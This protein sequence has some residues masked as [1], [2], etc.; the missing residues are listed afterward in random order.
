MLRFLI[1]ASFALF[2]ISCQDYGQLEMKGSLERTL[3]EVSGLALFEGDTLIYT[4][5]DHGNPNI[6]YGLD[7]SGNIVRELKISNAPNEDWEDLA[8][9]AKGTLYIS[10]TG[11]NENDREDQFIYYS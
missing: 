4:A 10:D 8:N 2:L 11:N 7:T 3:A 1:G 6:I 5:T 9:D